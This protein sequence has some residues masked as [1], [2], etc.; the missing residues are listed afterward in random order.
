L[1]NTRVGDSFRCNYPYVAL[2]LLILIFGLIGMIIGKYFLKNNKKIK[3]AL[4]KR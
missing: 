4:K 2:I 3:L 1:S